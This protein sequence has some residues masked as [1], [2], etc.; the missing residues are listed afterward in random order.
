MGK[1]VLFHKFQLHGI[2]DWHRARWMRLHAPESRPQ[3]HRP[4]WPP[5]LCGPIE[6][7]LPH[8]HP[9]Y[10]HVRG[11]GR[12]LRG[13]GRHGRFHAASGPRPGAL[14]DVRLRL[15]PAGRPRS[16]S[17]LPPGRGLGLGT[18]E[19]GGCN[20]ALGGR[21]VHRGPSRAQ[22]DGPPG[23]TR[24]G[25]RPCGLRQG[26]DHLPQPGHGCAC[27]WHRA[28]RRW[29]CVGVVIGRLRSETMA[30]CNLLE[31]LR[32]EGETCPVPYVC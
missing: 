8:H 21:R 31:C 27:G 17:L 25:Q 6:V 18:R 23:P 13:F 7:L 1:C 9:R 12:S 15:G 26:P 11:L 14:C 4:G 2:W 30:V 10:G 3:F 29:R 24:W 32:L 28:A 22:A 19:R 16:A 5:Q 20:I